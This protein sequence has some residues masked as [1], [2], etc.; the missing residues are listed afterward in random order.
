MPHASLWIVC[1]LFGPVFQ[2]ARWKWI[3][4]LCLLAL[5]ICGCGSEQTEHVDVIP[6]TIGDASLVYERSTAPVN[7]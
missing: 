5:A 6:E 4:G 1:F 2:S 3:V 7:P